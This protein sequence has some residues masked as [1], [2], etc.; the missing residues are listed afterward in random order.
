MRS[1]LQAM[2][3]MLVDDN[4]HVRAILHSILDGMGVK[5]IMECG[6]GAT[7][8]ETLRKWPADIVIADYQMA[9]VDG[10]EFTYLVRNSPDS[11]DRYLP[12][13]MVTGY[14]DKKRVYEARDAGVTEIIVKPITARAVMDRLNYVI[15]KPRPFIQADGY[16]GPDRRRV[17]EAHFD[18]PWRR[19]GDEK[20]ARV[21]VAV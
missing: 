2:R 3:I 15:F 10:V 4:P 14:A 18:G 9:P 5:H 21:A 6:D 7:A 11:T 19:A 17:N 16:F 13:I 20:A 8:L 12:I 1:P